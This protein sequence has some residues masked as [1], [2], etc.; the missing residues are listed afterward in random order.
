MVSIYASTMY[1]SD[2]PYI[3]YV[4]T[5][6]RQHLTV[7]CLKRHVNR[8]LSGRVWHGMPQVGANSFR[9]PVEVFLALAVVEIDTLQKRSIGFCILKTTYEMYKMATNK[10]VYMVIMMISY[11]VYYLL[12]TISLYT[13][14]TLSIINISIIYLSISQ[15]R[16]RV[17]RPPRLR[18]FQ[19][20][21]LLNALGWRPGEQRVVPRSPS[22]L[23]TAPAGP[24]LPARLARAVVLHLES[25]LSL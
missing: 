14:L 1:K 22:Q 12:L 16:R 7:S 11:Q 3:S 21:Q 5:S 17:I 9:G 20:R 13:C 10:I 15:R 25:S 8:A 18:P 24:V 2:V 4:I 6:R 23:L 19:Q